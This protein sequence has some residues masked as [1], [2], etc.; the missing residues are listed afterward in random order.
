[1]SSRI[2]VSFNSIHDKFGKHIVKR[3]KHGLS[4]F[5]RD[6]MKTKN[7]SFRDVERISNGTISYGT[8]AA[9]KNKISGDVKNETLV[10]LAKG[11]GVPEEQIFN[12]ARGLPPVND[13]HFS[14]F[15]Y[16][17]YNG[18]ELNEKELAELRNIFESIV[19]S[20]VEMK[21]KEKREQERLS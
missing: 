1:M 15:I 6:V 17:C 19:K 11:L 7:L 8:V 10:A 13:D 20:K 16:E 21:E 14:G 2:N 12:V 3:M 9:I 5:V 18:D 4:E